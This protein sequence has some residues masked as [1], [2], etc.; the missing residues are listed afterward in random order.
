MKHLYEISNVISKPNVTNLN[1]NYVTKTLNTS[2]KSKENNIIYTKR[3]NNDIISLKKLKMTRYFGYI[4][5]RMKSVDK[6]IHDNKFNYVF[7]LKCKWIDNTILEEGIYNSINDTPLDFWI[8]SNV[9]KSKDNKESSQK[10]D[11]FNIKVRDYSTIHNIYKY[12]P[13][14]IF[15]ISNDTTIKDYNNFIENYTEPEYKHFNCSK[16]YNLIPKIII[17]DNNKYTYQE[18]L[19]MSTDTTC[20][21][22]FIK[23]INNYNNSIYKRS[24]TKEYDDNLTYSELLFLYNRYKC[25]IKTNCV[26]VN[27]DDLKLFTI[28]YIYTLL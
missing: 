6:L 12:A 5:P 13:I 2:N 11:N 25:T 8:D 17:N 27:N 3:S 10:Y 21:N 23:Y 19:N 28:R 14:T 24:H 16:L 18:I 1:I 7:N 22:K 15:D 26:G 4:L 20:I 9:D